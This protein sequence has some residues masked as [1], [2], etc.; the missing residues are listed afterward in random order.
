VIRDGGWGPGT[1]GG[2]GAGFRGPGA[3]VVQTRVRAPDTNPQSQRERAIP[4]K[5]DP[6]P[7]VTAADDPRIGRLIGA[8]LED[9]AEPRVVLVGFP[10]DEGVR[11]NGGRTG[12]RKAPI[13]IRK[14]FHRLTP[15]PENSADFCRLLARTADLGDVE[16]TGDLERDQRG[17]AKAI[18]PY[19][20]RGTVVVVVGGGHETSFG[21]FL[22]Y[23][24]AGRPMEILN[25]DAHPDVR[26]FEEGR[27]HSGSP[28]RQALLHQS[29]FCR[30]Y[31]AAGL[32]RHSAA[33]AHVRFV[34]SKGAV[35]FADEVNAGLVGRLYGEIEEDALV[36]FDLDA[37]DQVFAPGVSAPAAGGLAPGLW[38][39]AAY[40]AGLCPKV[41]SVDLVEVNP[42]HDPDGRTARLAAVTLWHLFR[43]LAGR[44]ERLPGA[45]L[46]ER[47]GS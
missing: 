47:R 20:A 3:G 5:R 46:G 33:E 19:M 21:H 41:R 18:A 44:G 30:R 22:G 31:R 38:L 23:A 29:G 43:G 1:G 4:G 6:S 7:A 14:H 26:E 45:G 10:S 17:L 13:E 37:V 39:E 27:G 28:F 40:R 15:D 2:M 35:Y 36:S 25:W 32:Q 9:D 8:G 24:E 42:S 12:A 34:A 16:V 11:R